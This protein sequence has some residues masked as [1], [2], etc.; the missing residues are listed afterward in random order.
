MAYQNVMDA[1]E[2][3][4]FEQGIDYEAAFDCPAGFENV[5]DY[6][7][8]LADV[9]QYADIEDGEGYAVGG[10]PAGPAPDINEEEIPF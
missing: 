1:Y 2:L 9:D 10:A 5:T 4:E 3:L 6:Q 8:Y 7:A